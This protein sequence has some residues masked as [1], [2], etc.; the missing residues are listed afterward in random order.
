M[1]MPYNVGI[2][3]QF[4]DSLHGK[5]QKSKMAAVPKFP[6]YSRRIPS[7]PSHAGGLD[8][9]ILDVLSKSLLQY[10]GRYRVGGKRTVKKQ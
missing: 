2:L 5:I 8:E 3:C 1:M 4:D 10:S 7:Y 6:R 9:T